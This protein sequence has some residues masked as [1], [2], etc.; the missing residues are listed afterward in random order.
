MP[1]A[2]AGF[3]SPLT[4]VSLFIE[5]LSGAQYESLEEAEEAW[6]ELVANGESK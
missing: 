5:H 4:H 2:G 1:V 3:D 6:K